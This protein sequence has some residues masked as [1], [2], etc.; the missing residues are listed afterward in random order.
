MAPEVIL[1]GTEVDRRVDIYAVGCV[2]YYLLTGQL[3]FEAD[4]PMKTFVK[5]VKETP[6]PP[7]QR[8]ELSV[9]KALDDL[10]LRC[11]E[12]DPDK[13]PQDAQELLE[14][15]TRCRVAGAWDH[16]RARVWWETHLPELCSTQR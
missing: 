9:P 4:T 11:L 15:M 10:I 6:V 2:A 3:V 8:T 5:H 12:K 13:R 7:S 1:G 16:E 14:Q